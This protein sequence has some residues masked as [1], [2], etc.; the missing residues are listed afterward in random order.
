[1]K[2]LLLDFG[3]YLACYF[4]FSVIGFVELLVFQ[5]IKLRS[6]S[7]AIDVAREC[8]SKT[9]V[10]LYIS[11]GAF[12]VGSLT[13]IFSLIVIGALLWVFPA[14][15]HYPIIGGIIRELFSLFP[16]KE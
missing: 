8:F 9:P 5:A 1:M 10:L 12:V 15:E 16:L 14:I 7:G 6:L 4:F 2:P 3:A 11:T 13:Y